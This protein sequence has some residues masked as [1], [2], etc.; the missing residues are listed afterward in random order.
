ME[1]RIRAFVEENKKMEDKQIVVENLAIG[2]FQV[3][4][5]VSSMSFN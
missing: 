4:E 2:V 1:S 3:L 5:L